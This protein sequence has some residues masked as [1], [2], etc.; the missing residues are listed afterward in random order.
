MLRRSMM[1]LSSAL[2]LSAAVVACATGRYPSP[3]FSAPIE[4]VKLK[5]VEKFWVG[6]KVSF[7]ADPEIEAAVLRGVYGFVVAEVVIDSNG[8][9]VEHKILQSEPNGFFTP[10]AEQLYEHS[11]YKPARENRARV[12]IRCVRTTFFG[13]SNEAAARFRQLVREKDW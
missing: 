7:S 10:A 12:P 8:E 1:R 3:H 5:E 9:I 2:I 11:R 4:S 6:K 13:N